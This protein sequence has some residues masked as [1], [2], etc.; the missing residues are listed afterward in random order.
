M[1]GMAEEADRVGDVATVLQLI[2]LG[3]AQR[4]SLDEINEAS[5]QAR[6]APAATV[7]AYAA[8]LR[9]FAA[10]VPPELA[11]VGGSRYTGKNRN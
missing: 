7:K 3:E 9:R 4:L 11:V 10:G 5:L 6:H 1:A 2:K 8:D